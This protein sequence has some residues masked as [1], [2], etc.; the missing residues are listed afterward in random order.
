MNDMRIRTAT[1]ADVPALVDIYAPYVRE[2][3]ISFEYEVPTLQDFES[4]VTRTL[5]RYPWIVAERDGTILGYAYASAFHPRMAYAWCADLSVYIA[6]GER[7]RGAGRVLER[8]VA[9]L[10]AALGYR[11]LYALVTEENAASIAFHEA[12]GYRRVAFFPEQGYKMGRWL[13]VYWLEKELNGAA[14]AE[15]FPRSMEELSAGERA[16]LLAEACDESV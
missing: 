6:C 4:R 13:G 10:C 5:T 15:H 3:A 14:C 1:T 11:R 7:R 16:R 2:T 9:A 12:V 8:A